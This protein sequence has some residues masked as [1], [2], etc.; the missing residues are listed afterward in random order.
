MAGSQRKAP[1]DKSRIPQNSLFYEKVIPILLIAM[2][3][4]TAVFIVVAAGVLLGFVPFR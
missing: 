4:L 3:V 1:R 2:A